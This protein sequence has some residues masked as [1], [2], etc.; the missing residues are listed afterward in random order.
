MM[1][2]EPKKRANGRP[3]CSMQILYLIQEAGGE[4][5][6]SEIRKELVKMGY[7][8]HCILEAYTRLERQN[9]IKYEGSSHS[10]KQIVL[11]APGYDL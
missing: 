11:L 8:N 2:E 10:S 5:K 3:V 9:R 7:G 1:L 6:R 4:M